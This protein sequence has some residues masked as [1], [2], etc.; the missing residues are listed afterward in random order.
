MIY[1]F[2]NMEGLRPEDFREFTRRQLLTE[3]QNPVRVGERIIPFRPV[4]TYKLKTGNIRFRPVAAAQ[5][6]PNATFPEGPLATFGE[7][8][9]E[10]LKI[11]LQYS[12]QE[13]DMIRFFEVYGSG[14]LQVPTAMA[15]NARM[16]LL[17]E[18]YRLLQA[19][20]IGWLDRCE[21]IRWRFLASDSY[22]IPDTGLVVSWSVPAGAKYTLTGTDIWTDYAN[23]DGIADME[24]MNQGAIDDHGTPITVYY[25]STTAFRHLMSQT[26]V[27][28]RLA[29][30]GL[31]G[32][33]G[34][35]V[36]ANP[37]GNTD[38]TANVSISSVERYMNDR[39]GNQG[40]GEAPMRIVLYDRTYNEFD[41][42]G[43][44]QP[45]ETRFLPTE[46]VV[47]ITGQP[48]VGPII[49]NPAARTPV[50]YFADGPVA[51]NG[52]ASGFY[53]FGEVQQSPYRYWIRGTGWGFPIVDERTVRQ[54][55]AW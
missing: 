35:Q 39:R 12:L 20:G 50:G 52:F 55:T 28:N 31:I 32:G 46:R 10:I 14:I 29:A 41:F 3:V 49:P 48:L 23:A 8:E 33:M 43:N 16:E 17:G 54:L 19:L 34:M 42:R 45:A 53:T 47:G 27:Q 30:F 22:T 2:S 18:P 11:A 25:M 9:Y 44:S 24:E 7:R 21:M 15:A 37:A 26:K 6:A 51:E 1:D 38:L 13:S 40:R 5:V 36:I 4:T